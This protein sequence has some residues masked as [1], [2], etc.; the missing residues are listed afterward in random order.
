MFIPNTLVQFAADHLLM[1]ITVGFSLASLPQDPTKHLLRNP[2][3]CDPDVSGHLHISVIASYACCTK[4]SWLPFTLSNSIHIRVVGFTYSW[5][6]RLLCHGLAFDE[7]FYFKCKSPRSAFNTSF[8]MMSIDFPLPFN[9]IMLM[10]LPCSLY[11]LVQKYS[12]FFSQVFHLLAV[13]FWSLDAS[14]VATH[15]HCLICWTLKT[16]SSFFDFFLPTLIKLIHQKAITDDKE[17]K[18]KIFR[19]KIT[20]VG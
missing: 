10:N 20:G 3:S 5:A 7:F 4:S 8:G 9:D 15:I 12:D 2:S 14:F 18:R 11:F 13:F 17:W 16:F 6:E 19:Q 1:S